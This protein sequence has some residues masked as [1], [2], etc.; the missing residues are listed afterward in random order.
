MKYIL[1]FAVA[2]ALYLILSLV[3]SFLNI[4]AGKRK[5]RRFFL[6]IFPLAQMLLWAIYVYWAFLQLFIGMVA[7]PILIGSVIVLMVVLIGWY[8]MRDFVSGI[9]LRSENAFEVGQQIQTAEVSGTIKRLGY[10]TMEIVS[11][12]GERVR[13]PFSLLA[14]QKIAKPAEISHWVE[15]FV[16]LQITTTYTPEKLHNMLKIRL[17]EMPWILSDNSVK[18]TV[19]RSEKDVYNAEIYLHLLSEEMVLKTQENIH[20]FVREVFE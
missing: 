16:R 20:A 15:Q 5:I 9:I 1:I 17:L 13:I 8:F 4:L 12:E 7:F 14:S 11:A 2:V 6:R 19:T 18:I 3:F 10:R